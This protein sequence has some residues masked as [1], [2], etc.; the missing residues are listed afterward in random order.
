[1]NFLNFANHTVTDPLNGATVGGM[2][3]DLDTHLGCEVR[4]L[5]GCLSEKAALANVLSKGFLQVNMFV[6]MQCQK[7]DRSMHVVGSGNQHPIEFVGHL[8]EHF[9]VVLE[10]SCAGV[11]ILVVFTFEKS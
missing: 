11:T 10:L 7:R 4:F 5:R 6:V 2:A 3:M 1:M 9:L 8:G